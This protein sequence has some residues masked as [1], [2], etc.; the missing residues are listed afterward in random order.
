MVILLSKKRTKNIKKV[1]VLTKGATILDKTIANLS[2]L[3]ETTL[4]TNDDTKPVKIPLVNI[5]AIVAKGFWLN[6]I[7]LLGSAPDNTTINTITPKIKPKNEASFI[8]NIAPPIMIGIST[9]VIGNAPKLIYVVN[10]CNTIMIA[11][12]IASKE[13]CLFF[14]F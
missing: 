8:P 10:I 11:D 5:T 2:F 6:I 12:K 3:L 1:P 9:R 13:T 7:I 4:Y 14:I